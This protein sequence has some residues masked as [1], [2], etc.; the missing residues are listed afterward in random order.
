M[1]ERSDHLRSIGSVRPPEAALTEEIA[2]ER[3]RRELLQRIMA[4][5]GPLPARLEHIAVDR[6]RG[7]ARSVASIAAVVLA[8][9]LFGGIVGGR[10]DDSPQRS[11][12]AH[13][14]PEVLS[15]DLIAQRTPQAV[16]EVAATQRFNLQVN[17]TDAGG[18]PTAQVDVSQSADGSVTRIDEL[19][20]SGGATRSTLLTSLGSTTETLSIDHASRTWAEHATENPEA[21]S[22][23]ER[24]VVFLAG[25]VDPSQIGV[26]WVAS[27]ATLRALLASG[28]FVVD[29]EVDGLVR[30]SGNVADLAEAGPVAAQL[31]GLVPGS[32]VELWI[33]SSSYLPT[34]IR[35]TD[36]S[37]AVSDTAVWWGGEDVSLPVPDGYERR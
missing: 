11:D 27:P 29:G 37:G 9:A 26:G 10:G 28:S 4:T 33:D 22:S 23:D 12:V 2:T 17:L 36:P 25:G 1:A 15:V 18:A 30:L 7:R 24:G 19:D 20:A 5:E 21:P 34:R 3:E 6:P 14:E 35:V 16:S 32:R 31:E 13:A 8:L